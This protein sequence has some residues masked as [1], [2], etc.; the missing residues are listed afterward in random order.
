VDT[1]HGWY[2]FA[3]MSEPF[4]HMVCLPGVSVGS[5]MPSL[6]DAGKEDGK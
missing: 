4:E 5:R 6:D 1:L 3:K 2:N